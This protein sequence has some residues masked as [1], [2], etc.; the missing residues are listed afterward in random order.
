M[1][2]KRLGVKERDRLG[3]KKGNEKRFW[4]R[5]V[6]ALQRECRSAVFEE[7]LG[8]RA[9]KANLG[10]VDPGELERAGCE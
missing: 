4:L 1:V 8:L 3:G 9:R 10:G 6:V 7:G 2:C 5:P